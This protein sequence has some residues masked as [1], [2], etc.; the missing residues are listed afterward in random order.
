MEGL[1]IGLVIVGLMAVVLSVLY[2]LREIRRLGDKNM[3]LLYKANRLRRESQIS[4]KFDGL[5]D[6]EL[7][8]C[9]SNGPD[10]PAWKGVEELIRRLMAGY[11]SEDFKSLEDRAFAIERMAAFNELLVMM[12]RWYRRS[13]VRD[14]GSG[15]G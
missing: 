15:V 4:V 13:E 7:L 1:T 8:H 5:S 12:N 2:L 3:T 9:L 10:A 14:P 6:E 11:Q